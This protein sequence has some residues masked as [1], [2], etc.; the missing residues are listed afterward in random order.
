MGAGGGERQRQR[1]RWGM[2]G[3]EERLID[4]KMVS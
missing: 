3:R 2:E 1:Q 4:R